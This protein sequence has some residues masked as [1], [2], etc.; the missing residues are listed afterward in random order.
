MPANILLHVSIGLLPVL[1]FLVALLALDSY[2]LVRMRA[3]LAAIAAG[4]VVAIACYFAN[5][6]LL[7]VLAVDFTTYSRYVGPLIEELG[8]GL[9]IVALL[10]FRRVGFLVDAAIFGF[11]VGA[12]FAI[13]ENVYYQHLVPNAGI[14]TW[15]VRGFGTAVMHGGA[16]AM[17][18]M[19]SLTMIERLQ[20]VTPL[21]FLPGLAVAVAVHAAYNHTFLSPHL[22]TLVVLFTLP[23]LMFL[24]FRRSEQATASWLGRGFDE[25]AEM[26]ESINS[27]HFADSPSGRYLASLKERFKGAVVADLLCYIRLHSELALRAKGILMMREGGFAAAIDDA[28]R[29]KLAEMRYLQRSIGTTGRLALRP[30]LRAGHKEIWQLRM[31]EGESGKTTPAGAHA[32]APVKTAD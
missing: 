12:G 14:G 23:P 19:I 7:R 18:A 32:S 11:A 6:L 27:G 1:G 30:L 10:G 20:K 22:T 31:L 16:T 21:A 13:V 2:K 28:T 26:I 8:K 25:D 3:V 17:L 24:V 4:V 5:A 15:V 9:V 29:E